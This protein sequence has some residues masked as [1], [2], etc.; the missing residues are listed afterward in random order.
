MATA[1]SVLAVTA[2]LSPVLHERDSYPLST[3]PMFSHDR[4]RVAVIDTAVG[5]DGEGRRRR[6]NP[7]LIAGGIEVIRAAVTVSRSITNGDTGAL[8]AEIAQRAAGRR[9]LVRIEVV[10][11]TH[12][13]VRHFTES[14]E[15]LTVTV[16]ASCPVL[17]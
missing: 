13:V 4:G 6:L 7:T 12:D 14:A 9:D 15:P 2:V 16:H 10:S 5:W 8:C 3:Y 11:E 17:R 1:V